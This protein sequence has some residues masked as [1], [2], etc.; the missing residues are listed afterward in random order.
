M[1]NPPDLVVIH[2]HPEWQ[3]PLFAALTHRG[4]AFEPFDL[5]KASFAL[6]EAPD[7]RLYFNQASPSAYVRGNARA[8]PLASAYLRAL[9]HA[10]RRVL[11]GS[12]AF[13]LELSKSEQAALLRRLGIATPRSIVFN[14][15]DAL[16]AVLA[17]R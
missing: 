4:M 13:A 7:A 15:V 5:K 9:E 16:R 2:E 14:D 3:R 1:S 6:D 10:G 12:R 8:V 11:N 17:Q